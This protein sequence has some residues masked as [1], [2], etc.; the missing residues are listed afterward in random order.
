MLTI[1]VP[2]LC[3][4][5]CRALLIVS[6]SLTQVVFASATSSTFTVLHTFDDMDGAAPMTPLIKGSDG[7]L[8]GTSVGQFYNDGTIFK[9]APDGSGFTVLHTFTSGD[10]AAPESAL[11]EGPDGNF[12]G[13]TA[14][15]GSSDAGTVFVMTPLG[16]LTTLHT[17]SYG[18]GYE[19][20]GMVLGRD[21]NFYGTTEQGGPD[22]AGVV[23]RITPT[24]AFEI[25]HNFTGV[26]GSD[27][28]GIVQGKDGVF[29]GVTYYGGPGGNYGTLFSITRSGKF[30][31]LHSFNGEDGGYATGTLVEDASGNFYGTTDF[32]T[33][34]AEGGTV[35]KFSPSHELTTLHRFSYGGPGGVYPDSGVILG[36][37]GVLF[38]TALEGGAK[39][40]GTVFELFPSG[41][42]VALYSFAELGD[43]G[44]PMAG[45]LRIGST[46]YG[47]TSEGGSLGSLSEGTLFSVTLSD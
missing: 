20:N 46:L 24:G 12:Y 17:F 14:Y 25:L 41:R 28:Q 7:N 3:R 19:P 11:I 22:N 39:G 8:Y 16:V 4:A 42:I 32:A 36:P 26:D 44:S 47:A 33:G 35:F 2:Q 30:T 43:G 34:A 5:G 9:I 21:G 15:G 31:S 45:L 40:A 13:T 27:P 1:N 37:G 29:Y 10:G 18:D 23:F 6:L 38:G